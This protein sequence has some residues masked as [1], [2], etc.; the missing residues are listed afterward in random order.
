MSQ[1]PDVFPQK[2]LKV[3]HFGQNMLITF[4]LIMLA[5]LIAIGLGAWGVG[6]GKAAYA[7]WKIGRD[8]HVL[9]DARINGECKTRKS[10]LT[11]C[12]VSIRHD[13]QEWKKSFS[14]FSVSSSSYSVAAIASNQ[15]PAQVTLDLA[16]NKALNRMLFAIGIFAI[17]LLVLFTSLETLFVALPRQRKLLAALNTAAAQP[18]QLV[19]V[20]AGKGAHNYS[21][22][23]NG[24]PERIQLNPEKL[25]PWVIGGS[26][27]K[28]QILAIAGKNGASPVPLAG[29]LANINGLSKQE[30]AEILQRI[31]AHFSA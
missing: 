22:H 29:E 7:D 16:A 8:H 18:W 19:A 12:D 4:A 3:A 5:I 1:F 21:P 11:S 28:P 14:F 26:D 9:P 20:E 10:V 27:E 13:G 24:K 15:D 25:K 23:I 30:K 17:G 6:L 31:D 2:P